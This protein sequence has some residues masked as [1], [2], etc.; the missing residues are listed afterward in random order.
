[1]K[2]TMTKTSRWKMLL[3]RAATVPVL[4]AMAMV[5]AV[6]NVMAA[7]PD[8]DSLTITITPSV[9][10]GVDID[11]ATAALVGSTDLTLTASLNQSIY[12]GTPATVDINGNFENQEV[13][14]TAEGLD[15][16][17]V[18]NDDGSQETDF[19]QVYALFSNTSKLE[20]SSASASIRTLSGEKLSCAPANTRHGT[21][22]CDAA[23]R[24]SK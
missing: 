5:F 15:T 7:D 1:M 6:G 19:V 9:D 3:R 17:G 24:P 4:C 14:L 12:M 2:R 10:Y 16:W 13:H 11:T 18:D 22:I 8:K 23:S 21:T 20:S